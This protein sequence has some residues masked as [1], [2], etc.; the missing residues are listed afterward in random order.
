MPSQAVLKKRLNLKMYNRSRPTGPDRGRGSRYNPKRYWSKR[1]KDYQIEGGEEGREIHLLMIAKQMQ[2]F[3]LWKVLEVGCGYG[4]VYTVL[5]ELD[6]L[7]REYRMCDFVKSMLTGCQERT[8]IRPDWWNGR[9]LPYPDNRFGLVCS[10]W[11]M[12]HVPRL[13]IQGL[14]AEH[15]RVSNRFLH[16]VSLAQHTGDLAPHCFVHNYRALFEDAR[17]DIVTEKIHQGQ[18]HWLLE[19]K[20]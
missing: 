13:Q 9:K 2:V 5:K 14:L 19:K 7:P 20:R 16:V 3:K 17:L 15:C 18:G 8:G 6:A 10:Y 4:N 12:L 11:V 1:G